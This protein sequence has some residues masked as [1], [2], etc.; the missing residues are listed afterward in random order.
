MR[1]FLLIVALIMLVATLLFAACENSEV[2]TPDSGSTSDASDA[3]DASYVGNESGNAQSKDESAPSEGSNSNDASSP[4][5]SSAPNDNSTPEQTE[6]DISVLYCSYSE[7]PYFAMVGRCNEGAV[8]TAECDG[9]TVSSTSYKGWFSLRL[10]CS[11]TSVKV[12]LSQTENGAETSTLNYTARPKTPSAD[13]WGVVTGGD[14]QFFFEKMLPDFQGKTIDKESTYAALTNKVEFR[15][16]QLRANNP[17]AEIIYLIVPSS[18]SVYPELVPEQYH[19]AASTT[20]LDK[21]MDALTAG[22]A[23]VIN[24]K[25]IFAQHKNDE[26]PLYYK[27]DS[28]WADYGAY[29][30]YDALFDYI[31]QKYPDAAPRG[32]DEFNWNEGY[33][34]SGDMTY[35]L[36]M[37]QT[38]VKEYAYYRTFNFDAPA[39]VTATPRYR[40]KTMLCYSDQVTYENVIRTNRSNLPTCV[41]MRDSY[42]TQI[43]DLIAERMDTTYY[44]GMWDYSWNASRLASE[45]PDYVIYVVA[46]WNLNAIVN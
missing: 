28:H 14:F 2:S 15:V 4:D 26:M 46:E 16:N 19:P 30:A 8:I 44:R 35:Y 38:E 43:Y 29:V 40:S 10:R 32:I 11:G 33:Y 1:K 5:D 21:T 3:S 17:D 7:K 27:L 36:Q 13:M 41:V 9:E 22:G 34:D 31:S 25:E 20:R 45:S 39:S 24:L 6:S 23:T 18:M 37:S 42:S 12:K